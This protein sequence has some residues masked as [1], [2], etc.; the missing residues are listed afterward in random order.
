MKTLIDVFDDPKFIK[1][2]QSK[3]PY[4]F[5]LA[6]KD[7]TRGGKLGMEIGSVR[8]RVLIGL[9]VSTFGSKNINHD[10][11]I[12]ESEIDVFVFNKGISIKTKTGTS[13]SGIKVIWTV[14]WEK[15]KQF[16]KSYTPQCDLLFVQI[17]WNGEG[18]IT[19]IPIG[20]QEKVLQNM[21]LENYLKAPP[22]NTNPRGVEFSKDAV[23]QMVEHKDTKKIP[24]FWKRP[25]IEYDA[26]QPWV[27]RWNE[28]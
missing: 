22:P 17:N 2:V 13:Y 4:F 12:T 11:P 6:E 5:A 26:I 3:L 7:A 18:K 1:L 14:D 10:I 21:G 19:Y 20:I 15:V 16:L 25:N 24:I 27:E 23:K 8:E 28:S 9:L